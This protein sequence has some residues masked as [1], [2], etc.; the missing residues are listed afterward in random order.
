MGSMEAVP[1]LGCGSGA[2][3]ST[4]TFSIK[5]VP[6]PD[7][8]LPNISREYSVYLPPS[9]SQSSP[10]P[11]V[12]VF[13]GWG[14][15]A[16]T[17]H[18][19]YGFDDLAR[20]NDFIAVYPQGLDDCQ[21]GADCQHMHSWNGG[22][23][24]N[25]DQACAKYSYVY[26][27]YY[28]YAYYYDYCYESCAAKSHGCNPCDWTTCY[29]DVAFVGEM[30]DSLQTEYCID[31][32][33]QYAIGCSNG[34]VMTFELVKNLPGQFAGI[35]SAC[36]ARPH[37][38]W[39]GTL[40]DGPPVSLIMIGGDRDK[41]IPLYDPPGVGPPTD[42]W[43]WDG[44]IWAG[45]RESSAHYVQKNG[46]VGTIAREF[47]VGLYTANDMSCVEDGYDCQGGT[48]V[49]RCVF[50]GGH[51]F[52]TGTGSDDMLDG[53]QIMWDFLNARPLI[54]YSSVTS[55]M[56]TPS[57]SATGTI[58][59]SS[60][61]S[62]TTVTS[63]ISTM[64]SMSG[65][66]TSTTAT[67][68]AATST[69]TLTITTTQIAPTPV[70]S[71]SVTSTT[72]TSSVRSS[73]IV[74]STTASSASTTQATATTLVY[75]VA[76][77]LSFES[78]GALDEVTNVVTSYL[79]SLY[80]VRDDQI[81]VSVAYASARSVFNSWD[82]GFEIVAPFVSAEQILDMTNEIVNDCSSFAANLKTHFQSQGMEM[83]ESSLTVAPPDMNV[84]PATVTSASVTV[85][86]TSAT[87]EA[88]TSTTTWTSI[89][90]PTTTATAISTATATATATAAP[91][92]DLSSAARRSSAAKP[93]AWWLALAAAGLIGARIG[94]RI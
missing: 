94:N 1:S 47:P 31:L 19:S 39:D 57:P 10:S 12:M 64:T 28:S 20:E 63:R 90:I 45:L 82:V 70:S 83:V 16:S 87:S 93:L 4:D 15:Q 59:S 54:G 71:P 24:T 78:S 89:A 26:T 5:T 81:L 2:N 72:V 6:S 18:T 23:T 88:V 55:A 30:L 86:N 65:T 9:Y 34:G 84:V 67:S 35:G 36:G 60:T 75:V 56:P 41:V 91:T 42:K 17:Y 37:A 66:V 92:G 61:R 13:H 68:E 27:Y 76:G 79:S 11:L 58:V 22:G 49:V 25:N 50:S 44:Y 69:I 62:S 46:C 48:S 40:G 53:P 73:T 74:A 52:N 3:P 32:R 80:G 7:L 85:N 43:W 8:D 21:A 77:S 38:G 33:R 14:E 29:D 51:D